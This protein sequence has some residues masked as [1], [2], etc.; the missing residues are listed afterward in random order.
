MERKLQERTAKRGR[1]GFDSGPVR[2][3]WEKFSKLTIKTNKKKRKRKVKHNKLIK[4][5]RKAIS[6]QSVPCIPLDKRSH[7]LSI[8][9]FL[10]FYK[11]KGAGKKQF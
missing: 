6:L 2:G 7:C 11:K 3:K 8:H 10:I 5:R 4:K 9:L 1:T